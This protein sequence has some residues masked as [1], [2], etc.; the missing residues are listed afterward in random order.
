[1][2]RRFV[3]SAK[4]VRATRRALAVACAAVGLASSASCAGLLGVDDVTYGT[5]DAAEDATDAGWS[6]ASD[7]A[8]AADG[9]DEP[10]GHDEGGDAQDGAVAPDAPVPSGPCLDGG[11]FFCDDFDRLDGSFVPPWTNESASNGGIGKIT[12]QG[13]APSFPNV[14][15]AT[16]MSG[17]TAQAF[18]NVSLAAATL[19]CVARMRLE[20]RGGEEAVPLALDMTASAPEKL[21]IEVHLTA[22]GSQ[23]DYVYDMA[24][25]PDGGTEAAHETDFA[26]IALAKWVSIEV[27]ITFGPTG[28][29]TFSIDGAQVLTRTGPPLTTFPMGSAM[30]LTLGLA[31]SSGTG[32][33]KADFDDVVCDTR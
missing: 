11:H 28:H 26:P 13:D 9:G 4:G 24:T 22:S 7:A 33:W 29:A 31:A 27:E 23:N 25:F 16:A 17:Q 19:R 2:L 18:R 1:M 5:L 21:R 30:A 32:T 20:S 6:P 3:H 10:A 8:T 14:F 15:Q 12:P